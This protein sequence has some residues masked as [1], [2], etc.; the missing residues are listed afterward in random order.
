MTRKILASLPGVGRII[1]P[2]CSRRLGRLATARLRGPAQPGRSRPRQ[3][4]VWQ[5]LHLSCD[6]RPAMTGSL[7]TIGRALPYN[8]TPEAEPNTQPCEG[9]VIA[10][11]APCDPS[12][13]V[14]SMSPAPC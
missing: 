14:C 10:M 8:T 1:L 2:R 7:T 11:A 12:P 5:E 4:E 13:I 9:E 6:A 3:Q